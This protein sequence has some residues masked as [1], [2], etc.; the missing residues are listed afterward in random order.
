MSPGLPD[1]KTG[2][3]LDQPPKIKE[4]ES[5]SVPDSTRQEAD[6]TAIV[7]RGLPHKQASFRKKVFSALIFNKLFSALRIPPPKKKLPGRQCKNLDRKYTD[8]K[9]VSLNQH[10]FMEVTV[11]QA[12]R[13]QAGCRQNVCATITSETVHDG[14]S[15]QGDG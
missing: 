1:R 13:A 12:F 10:E 4:S 3:D 7:A 15:P 14:C 11:H 2:S 5:R 6:R 8:T 9:S